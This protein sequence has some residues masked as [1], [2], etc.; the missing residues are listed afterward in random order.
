MGSPRG[1]VTDTSVTTETTYGVGARKD[2]V[3]FWLDSSPTTSYLSLEGKVTAEVVI[4][5]GGIVGLTSAL[6]LAESGLSVVVLEADRIASGVSGYTT[7]KLTAGH[8]LLYS[9]LESAFDEATAHA[10][11]QSQ[12]AAI[13][14]VRRL[15]AKHAIECD[16][17]TRPN[18]IYT[19]DE[20]DVD[21]IEKEAEAARRAGLSVEVTADVGL[22]FPVRSALRLAD[23]AQFHPRAYLLA[24]ASQAE[25]AG[26]RLFERTRVGEITGTSPYQV[27]AEGGIAVGE[28]VIVAT[29]Y[30]IV[31]H[32][33]FATRLHPRRSYV[34]A[35]AM[36]DGTDLEGMYINAATPTRS[37]RTAPL[38]G[39]RRLLLVGGEG[40][41]VGESEAT[42]ARY[43]ALENFMHNAFEVGE[44]RYRWSTQDPTSID[45]LPYVGEVEQGAGV[46]VASGFGGWGMSNGT[47]AATLLA[48]A[49]GGVENEWAPIYAL[50]RGRVAAAARRFLT[51]NTRVAVHQVGGNLRA[52]RGAD[53][54]PAG[55]ATVTMHEGEPVAL[56]HAAN[57]ERRAV[58]A[59]CTHMGCIVEWNAA[60][61]SW[62]CPCH[63]SRFATDG[64]VLHGPAAANLAVIDMA[65]AQES[66]EEDD[67]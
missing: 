35:A 48:D 42:S 19:D 51:E 23:Q 64:R 6:F 29:H 8:G 1:G 36:S 30:P 20:K 28:R 45:R 37:L 9:H 65:V 2:R 7:A 25:R 50:D 61:S 22:P 38:P 54:I 39:D 17:E 47:L 15:V 18:V 21:A 66:P 41:P 34:V 4:L 59:R 5:G 31:E 67:S 44:T 52:R 53:D 24:V 40:H 27:H 60:E 55:R 10:Y 16:L 46:Y 63:G 3:S 58:S 26:V 14:T 32:G 13:E 43:K 57:G 33:F 12:L 11:G 49:F 56:F 62:D